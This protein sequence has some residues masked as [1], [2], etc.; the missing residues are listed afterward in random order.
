MAVCTA[1]CGRLTRSW[2]EARYELISW[3][4]SKT[5]KTCWA[6]RWMWL[7]RK[8]LALRYGP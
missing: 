3:P 2:A 5:W 1:P 4:L 6:V 7:R 8:P